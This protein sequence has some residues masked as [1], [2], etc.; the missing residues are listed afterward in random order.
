MS[1]DLTKGLTRI[2]DTTKTYYVLGYEP[3]PERKPGFRRIKVAVKP[4]GLQVLARRGYFD[5]RRP[6]ESERR[7]VP[8]QPG[9]PR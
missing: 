2:L 5:D 1:G 9:L 4:K 3:P 7:R 8:R 6:D